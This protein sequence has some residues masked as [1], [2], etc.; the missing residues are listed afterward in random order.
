ML[1]EEERDLFLAEY[2]YDSM[3]A[4]DFTRQQLVT[5]VAALHKLAPRHRY[6]TAMKVLDAWASNLPLRQAPAIPVDV[7]VVIS[8]FLVASAKHA[9]GTLLLMCF[10]GVL[11]VNEPLSLRYCD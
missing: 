2:I 7:A 3:D 4:G 1:F 9:I 11:R 8:T 10:K 5:L 6:K